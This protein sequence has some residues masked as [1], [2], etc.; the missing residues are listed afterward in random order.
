MPPACTSLHNTFRLNMVT[1][2]L[3][4]PSFSPLIYM[5]YYGILL[6]LA[7]NAR[8]VCTPASGVLDSPH[9]R[10]A[11]DKLRA[12]AV[13]TTIFEHTCYYQILWCA[14]ALEWVP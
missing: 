3:A 13:T 8:S 12:Q 4:S 2:R 14:T 7:I 9:I 1:F 10:D 6:A 5:T 11:I